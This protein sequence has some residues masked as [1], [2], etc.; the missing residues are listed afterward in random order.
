[1]LKSKNIRV[2]FEMS[3]RQCVASIITCKKNT[4]R[5]LTSYH[6]CPL[7]RFTMDL[8]LFHGCGKV[9]SYFL[10]G[11]CR[12]PSRALLV[13]QLDDFSKFDSQLFQ[14]ILRL[15]RYWKFRHMLIQSRE[16]Q[17]GKKIGNGQMRAG[18]KKTTKD[19]AL[20]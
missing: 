19:V 17:A 15:R 3:E 2:T 12:P 6:P 11:I 4:R 7:S 1:M 8:K 20:S 9:S 14:R 16:Q 5:T 18:M 10:S 13:W